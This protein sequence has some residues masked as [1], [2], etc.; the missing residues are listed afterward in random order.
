VI[1]EVFA[2][3]ARREAEALG[4]DALPLVIIPHPVGQLSKQVMREITDR[5]LEEILFA[6]SGDVASLVQRYTRQRNTS[7]Q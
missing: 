1:T 7:V 5:Y 6:L 4:M 2:A 3:K